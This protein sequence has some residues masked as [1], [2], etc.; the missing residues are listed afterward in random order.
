MKVDRYL[1][2]KN[3]EEA[4]DYLCRY[5]GKAKV[6]AGGT[7]LM[8]WI[9]EGKVQA[10]AL[11]DITEID[12][13]RHIEFTESE[14]I[15]GAA[16]TH[17]E[18]ASNE[19][20]KKCFPCLS[21]GCRYVGSPQIRNIGTVGGNI[22]SAQP[23]ADSAI[24]LIALGAV[25]EILTE[26]GLRKDPLEEL[27]AGVG[28]SKIDSTREI[29]IRI[30]VPRPDSRYGTSLTRFA[31]REALALP[32]ANTAVKLEIED[33]II[34]DIRIAMAPVAT[35]PLRPKKA[36]QYLLGRDIQTPEIFK[37]AAKIAAGEANPRDSLLRGSSKYRKALA[38][39]LVNN[40]LGNAAKNILK[41][42]EVL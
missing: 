29:L 28:K 37:E 3:V 23:A 34:K 31:P 15:I 32:I 30:I 19:N 5:S 14:M 42:M 16:V 41:N 38:E 24:P 10:N 39:D 25:C 7:D 35:T 6:I 18:I 17:A 40:A 27:Y 11:I 8:L 26:D 13:L 36:E 4:I 33:N 12:E 20:I 9:K 1:I 22:V 21:D 2:P